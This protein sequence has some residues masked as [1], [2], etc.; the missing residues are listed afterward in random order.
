MGAAALAAKSGADGKDWSSDAGEVAG[1][2]VVAGAP[3]DLD[4]ARVNVLNVNQEAGEPVF[5]VGDRVAEEGE[6]VY[7]GLC[8]K[9]CTAVLRYALV[10][11]ELTGADLSNG[12]L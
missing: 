4:D 2:D 3:R 9:G 5:D 10:T 11:A 1:N 8:Q 6:G 12:A 7:I